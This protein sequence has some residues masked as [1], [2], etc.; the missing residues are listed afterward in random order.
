MTIKNVS[1][2]PLHLD[3]NVRPPFAIVQKQGTY[4]IIP[5]EENLCCCITYNESDLNIENI[6]TEAGPHQSKIFIDYLT[7]R[8]VEPLRP[9]KLAFFQDIHKI[10]MAFHLTHSV[11]ELL[12]DEEVMKLQ[13]LFDTTK[14]TT[15]KSKI[16]SDVMRLK[17]KGHK[18]K[19]STYLMLFS[20]YYRMINKA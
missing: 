4:K 18:N 10:K 12:E 19:V 14:H 7:L 11:D 1:K 13:L 8:P 15:L 6:I 5:E 16:Y 20:I 3:I 2:L 9:G 17:F